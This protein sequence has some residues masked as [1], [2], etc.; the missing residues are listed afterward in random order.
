[1]KT[2]ILVSISVH[3]Q[4]VLNGFK[5]DLLHLLGKN[6]SRNEHT[7]SAIKGKSNDYAKIAPLPGLSTGW[8]WGRFASIETRQSFALP[9]GHYI[10]RFLSVQEKSPDVLNP[11]K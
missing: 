11:E 1:M 4:G 10:Y 5:H 2:G 7:L 8:C 6:C 9:C 3:L